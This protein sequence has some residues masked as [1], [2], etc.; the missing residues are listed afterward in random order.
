MRQ[1]I[2]IAVLA[3]GVAACGDS[4]SDGAATAAPTTAAPAT[5]EVPAT[6]AAPAADPAAVEIVEF[7]FGPDMLTVPLGT[8]V[9]WTNNEIGV[10]HTTTAD[11]GAW[12]SGTMAEGDTFSHTF[13]E[14][15]TF[16]YFCSIHPSMTATVNVTG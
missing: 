5:T 15:G 14:E 7:A 9:T 2:L 10:P 11:D 3:L 1:L 12:D 8:T 4:G 6:T 13:T 16:T